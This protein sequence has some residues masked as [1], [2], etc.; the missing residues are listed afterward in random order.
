MLHGVRGQGVLA[1]KCCANTL[2]MDVEW[3]FLVDIG[4][5]NRWIL[6]KGMPI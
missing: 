4:R 1:W 5:V 3:S 2:R 6:T